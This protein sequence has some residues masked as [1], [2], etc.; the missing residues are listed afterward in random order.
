MTIGKSLNVLCLAYH[1]LPAKIQMAGK[2]Y[3]SRRKTLHVC[4]VVRIKYITN[5]TT[6][7][8]RSGSSAKFW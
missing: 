3:L 5:R 8:N 4:E 6:F 7:P 2:F 1:T